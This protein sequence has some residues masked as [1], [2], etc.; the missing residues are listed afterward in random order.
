MSCRRITFPNHAGF[1]K[2]LNA[3]VDE[4]FEKRKLSPRDQPAMFIKTAII[5]AWLGVGYFLVVFVPAPIWLKLL[6]CMLLGL[7]IAAFVFNVGHDGN[8]GAY[9]DREWVNR[10][11]GLSF[12]LMG[13]S[14][15][16]WRYRH[17]VVH[18]TYT[19]IAGVDV[20][21]ASAGDLLRYTRDQRRLPFHR[22]QH[23]YA[24]V[25]YCFLAFD[26]LRSDF[27]VLF[28]ARAYNQHVIPKPKAADLLQY[29][30]S[31]VLIIGYIIV[32][33]I[34]LMGF[35]WFQWAAGVF[36]CY[37][38]VGIMLSV[39]FQLAH[40]VDRADFIIPH[41]EE[42]QMTDEWAVH[43]LRTSVDF[44]PTS[45]VLNW[46]LGGL[47]YQ[48]LHHLFPRISHVHYPQLRHVV[49]QVCDEHG[50]EYRVH[51]TVWDA[52]KAHRRLLKELGQPV[53]GLAA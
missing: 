48:A 51:N 36:A 21:I 39:V 5:L 37:S 30:A 19:N 45:R 11:M 6:E 46:F 15:F 7:G 44:S 12:D 24:W 38:V 4:F 16:L 23:W 50:I 1:R 31:K 40:V 20:D 13:A 25:L 9:S 22:F 26:W 17:N 8:H 53:A 43:Q 52:L 10:L 42:H 41:G 35:T 34:F 3:R 49:Q 14:G 2:A 27:Y 33:P 18:H 32:V 29:V 28:I 47:N